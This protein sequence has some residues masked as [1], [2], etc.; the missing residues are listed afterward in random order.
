[1][2]PCRNGRDNVVQYCSKQVR[3][4]VKC[5]ILLHIPRFPVDTSTL[6]TNVP[7]GN[8]WAYICSRSW[9][10]VRKSQRQCYSVLFQA[11]INNN[12]NNNNNNSNNNDYYYYY[13]LYFTNIL[14][15]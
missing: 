15:F 2:N 12:N 3:F 11:K 7:W 13:N 14:K 10:S 6:I 8:Y 4:I 9:E 1:M 5:L